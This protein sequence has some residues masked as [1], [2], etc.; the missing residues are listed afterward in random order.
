MWRDPD[1]D[2]AKPAVYYARALEI[3]T[4]RWSTLL[5]IKNHLPIPKGLPPHSGTGLDVA[6]LVHADKILNGRARR[7][8]P[9]NYCCRV[10]DCGVFAR[11][12]G[13]TPWGR[14]CDAHAD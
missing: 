11:V 4:P 10:R 9:T 13:N 12:P 14:H 1:F 2:P 7:E 3:P 8:K 5:A 6:D